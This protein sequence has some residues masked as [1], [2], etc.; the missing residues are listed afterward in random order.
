MNI[1]QLLLLHQRYDIS[2]QIYLD[3]FREGNLAIT[4]DFDSS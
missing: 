4:G 1:V 2:R 3:A